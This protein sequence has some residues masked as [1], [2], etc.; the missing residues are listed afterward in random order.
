MLERTGGPLTVEEWGAEI[1]TIGGL[2]MVRLLQTRA[3]RPVDIEAMQLRRRTRT[4]DLLNR[5][6]VL[7]GVRAWLDEA[8]ALGLPL[9]IASSSERTWV[10]PNLKR[11]GLCDRFAHL[12]CAGGTIAPKPAPDT[13]LDACAALG[14]EPGDA[15]AIEDSPH[16]VTAAT[17]A[18]LRCIAVPHAITA[19]LDLSHADLVLTSLADMALSE[20]ITNLRG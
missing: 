4:S 14:V 13:Y 15:L 3:D 11:L 16:G 10:V 18:G 20:A 17:R 2:D 1:G 12:A 7:P 6:E 8:D 19:Q 5:E 9:A